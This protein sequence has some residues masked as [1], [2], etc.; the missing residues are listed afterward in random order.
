MGELDAVDGPC[1]LPRT[2]HHPV[3]LRQLAT[4]PPNHPQRH[5]VEPILRDALDDP[6]LMVALQVQLGLGDH[7]QAVVG[8]RPIA[9]HIPQDHHPRDAQPLHLIQHRLLCRP[10]AMDIGQDRDHSANL[11]PQDLT[12]KP[13]QQVRLY[14]N[15]INSGGLFLVLPRFQVKVE[16]NYE[17]PSPD[18]ALCPWLVGLC[19]R[20]PCRESHR[21]E[22]HHE[23][24]MPYKSL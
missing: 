21:R 5:V 22:Y 15:N 8:E 12:L 20:K 10:V 9:D 6:R 19:L 23:C 17:T 24:S 13:D 1:A 11:A 3:R 4:R 14:Y 2:D 16:R 7:P 18:F